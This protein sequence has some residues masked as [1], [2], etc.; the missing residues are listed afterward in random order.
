LYQGSHPT[1]IYAADFYQLTCDIDWNDNAL[2][3]AFR[4]GLQDDVKDLLLKL[5]DPLTLT[6]IITQLVRYNNQLFNRREKWRPTQG[7]YKTEAITLWKQTPTNASMPKP[8]Q[9]DSSRFK[10]V[11]QK[12][13]ER[14]RKKDLYLYCS[15]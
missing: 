6:K 9:I 2:I 3:S 7:L 15:E 12:E 5:L 8:M 1:S 13:K 14:Q 10:K 11:S 4:W